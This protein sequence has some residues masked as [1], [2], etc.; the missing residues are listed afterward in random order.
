[1]GGTF[2][3]RVEGVATWDSKILISLVSKKGEKSKKRIRQSSAENVRF[4]NSFK[5]EKCLMMEK[6]K[7]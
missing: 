6:K 4:G 2:I 1:M 5:T 3:R 7:I